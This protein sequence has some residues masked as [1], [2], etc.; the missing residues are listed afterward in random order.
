MRLHALAGALILLTAF[1]PNCPGRTAEYFNPDGTFKGAFSIALQCSL[2]WGPEKVGVPQDTESNELILTFPM[3]AQPSAPF[4]AGSNVLFIIWKDGPGHTD[5]VFSWRDCARIEVTNL[6]QLSTLYGAFA[7]CK[8][9]AVFA[10]PVRSDL[11][12]EG[13]FSVAYSETP[14]KPGALTYEWREHGYQYA[15]RYYDCYGWVNMP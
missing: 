14:G 8:G 7:T 9:D 13:D 10:L 11:K 4:I 1:A 3:P 5:V 2:L 6:G 12:Y 15:R